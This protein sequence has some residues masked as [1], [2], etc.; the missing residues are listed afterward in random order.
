M[1]LAP[2]AVTNSFFNGLL[3]MLTISIVVDCCQSWESGIMNL[4]QIQMLVGN[5]RKRLHCSYPTHTWR[6]NSLLVPLNVLRWKWKHPPLNGPRL[7]SL[8]VYLACL[9]RWAMGLVKWLTA[10]KKT[11]PFFGQFSPVANQ[12]S[13]IVISKLLITR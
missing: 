3:N 5:L 10:G 8:D 4:P 1:D 12:S 2:K 13:R 9:L 7:W 11:T 6:G